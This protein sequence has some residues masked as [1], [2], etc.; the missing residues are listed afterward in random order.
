MKLKISTF[1][2][3]PLNVFLFRNMSPRI[4]QKYLH[5]IGFF[6]YL[7]NRR[8]KRVIER[9]V[10]EVLA[11][12]EERYVRT[13]VRETFKGIFTHYFEKM[14]SAYLDFETVNRY[15]ETHFDVQGASWSRRRSRKA[16]GASW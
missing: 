7:V 13:V 2:Q 3:S 9:N 12:R 6:Y 14:F 1:F 4:A 15:V 5:A 8:E 16:R 10:R 11:G